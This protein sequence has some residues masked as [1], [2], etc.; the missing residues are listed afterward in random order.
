MAQ[1]E[2][3]KYLRSANN[4]VFNFH[5]IGNKK[6]KNSGPPP[7]TRTAGQR[8]SKAYSKKSKG[9]SQRKSQKKGKM[10]GIVISTSAPF[11]DDDAKRRSWEF[12][13][14]GSFAKKRY[15]APIGESYPD[16]G[17]KKKRKVD[18]RSGGKLE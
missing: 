13:K 17:G 15:H 14:E 9:N 4:D 16:S 6:R 5:R 10:I 18:Y 8:K 7:E 12:R 11:S 2:T 3:W 1:K